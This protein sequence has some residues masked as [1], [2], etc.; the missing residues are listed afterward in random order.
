MEFGLSHEQTLLA[1]SV[2]R[3][4]TDQAPLDRVRRFTA[5]GDDGDIWDGLCSL[6]IPSLLVPEE[7]GGAELSCLEAALV[8]EVL[9]Y[10]AT[11]APF[12]GTAVAAPVAL[13]GAGDEH[14]RL[15][16]I[17]AGSLRVGLAA[18]QSTGARGDAGVL[19]KGGRLSGKALFVTDFPA[20]A[21]LVADDERRLHLV[22]AGA[23]GLTGRRLTTI[24]RTRP[25]GE[26]GFDGTRALLSIDDPAVLDRVL[27]AARVAL[28]A[29]TL[30]AAQRMLDQAV[31]YAGERRQFNRPIGSFQAVKHACADM[32]VHIAVTRQLV[33]AA[34]ESV[35]HG[36]DDGAASMAKSYASTAAVDIAGKAMQ[37][38]GGIGYTWESG[39]HV[40][41]KRAAL[42]RSLFGSPAV[43]R[44]ELAKRYV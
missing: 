14:D 25:T 2:G 36:R 40:Y 42:N 6:G 32:Q 30:G 44:K 41:L 3:F 43:H 29:D 11:P 15:A 10:H 22:S 4:L 37:L 27:D 16:A 8:A 34:I 39:I 31:A 18:G 9:G 12:L 17:A 28:A 20:D 23:E 5:D 1:D 21:Y 19:F 38:H 7:A 33:R 13:R 24:D 35:V 26:L